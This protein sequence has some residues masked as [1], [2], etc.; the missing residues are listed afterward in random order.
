MLPD[1]EGIGADEETLYASNVCREV[2]DEGGNTV[3]FLACQFSIFDRLDMF[4]L[5]RRQLHPFV[6]SIIYLP[7][8]CREGI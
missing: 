3:S 8:V 1:F 5:L 6:V 2:F 4:V 7:P